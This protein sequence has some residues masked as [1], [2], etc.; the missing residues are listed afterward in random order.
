MRKTTHIGR[1]NVAISCSKSLKEY[2]R[3]VISKVGNYWHTS[4]LKSDS[5]RPQ[6]DASRKCKSSDR[7]FFN[8]YF[9]I[10]KNIDFITCGTSSLLHTY[11][12]ENSNIIKNNL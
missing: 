12:C 7:Q 10:G 11:K 2:N 1:D 9:L 3:N 4:T 8:H 5:Q 6:L